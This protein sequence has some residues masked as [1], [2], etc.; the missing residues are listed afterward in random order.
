MRDF[1][2]VKKSDKTKATLRV[3][4][5]SDDFEK[6]TV[7]WM[8]GVKGTEFQNILPWHQG[9]VISMTEIEEWAKQNSENYSVY[10]YGSE[11][12]IL[13]GAET[14]EIT[15]TPTIAGATK[16]KVTMKGT[17]EGMPDI[18]DTFEVENSVSKKVKGIDGYNYS[19]TLVDEN[20]SWTS[21]APS[22]FDCDGDKSVELGI[23]ISLD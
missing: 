1:C 10:E 23:T 12:I 20:A 15:I 17:F 6:F 19:F 9:S 21:S 11:Q 7:M 16:A 2:I 5:V 18:N 13:V 8:E 22:A 3:D 4:I 14:H